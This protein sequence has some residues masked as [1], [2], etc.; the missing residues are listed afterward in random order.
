MKGRYM[1]I[2]LI[3]EYEEYGSHNVEASTDK[4]LFQEIVERRIAEYPDSKYQKLAREKLLEL[5]DAD[6]LIDG[7]D[8]GKTWGGLQVHIVETK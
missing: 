8:L 1:K 6:N 3:S 2:Y 4:K 5:L 7:K